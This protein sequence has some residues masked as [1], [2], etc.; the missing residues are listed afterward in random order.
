MLDLTRRS[1][2]TLHREVDD[3]FNR[4]FGNAWRQSRPDQGDET[5]SW[6]PAEPGSR[7]PVPPPVAMDAPRERAAVAEVAAA[8]TSRGRR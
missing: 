5:P 4:F 8:R 7:A 3:I 2:F 6:W 1:P